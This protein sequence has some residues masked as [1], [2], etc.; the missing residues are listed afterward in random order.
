MAEKEEPIS[1]KEAY[2]NLRKQMNYALIKVQR[3]RRL[4]A[5]SCK[6]ADASTTPTRIGSSLLACRAN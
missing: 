1:D 5:W 2:E 4:G 6:T 3:A